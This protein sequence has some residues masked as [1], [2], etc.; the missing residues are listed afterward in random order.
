M[1]RKQNFQINTGT[2]KGENLGIRFI[3]SKQKGLTIKE[4]AI[5]VVRR[6]KM[7]REFWGLRGVDLNIERGE[8]VGIIGRN[9]SGKSTLLRL[10]AK[11]YKPDE[12]RIRVNGRI[13]AL[14]ELSAGLNP[15]LTGEENIFLN[16][17]ILG[18]KRS[19]V[20]EIYDQIVEFSELKEFIGQPVK[21]YSAGMKLRLGFSTAVHMNPDI[22]LV[23]EV[24][25]VGDQEFKEKCYNRLEELMGKG[26]TVILVSHNLNEIRRF[27]NRTIWLN[28][29]RLLMEDSTETVLEQYIKSM[30]QE[31]PG[32]E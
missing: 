4:A 6:R 14:I 9:G 18:M 17:A 15:D 12:G 16:G 29:G 2:V 21:F 25:A 13:G 20:S 19:E 30:E 28:A 3:L 1:T 5:N 22:F 27:C 10:I 24:I 7:R 23:D 8:V 32:N 31:Q 26:I 11:V